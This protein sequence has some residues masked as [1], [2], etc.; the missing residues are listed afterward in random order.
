MRER[1]F[2]PLDMKDTSFHVPADKIDRLPTCYRFNHQM[3]QLEVYDGI[4]DSAWREPAMELGSGGLVGSADDYFAF[5]RMMLDKGRHG[6]EQVLSRASV[7][8]MTSDQLTSNSVKGPNSSS[9]RTAAGDL[10]WVWTRNATTSTAAPDASVG[11]AGSAF[12]RTRTPRRASSASCSPNAWPIRRGHRRYI[13]TSGRSPTERCCKAAGPASH[14]TQFVGADAGRTTTMVVPSPD[15]P[16]SPLLP[17]APVLPSL[18][19]MPVAPCGPA[20]PGTVTTGPGTATM[21]PGT[22]TTGPGT[23]TTAAGVFTTV[24][25]SQATRLNGTSRAAIHMERFI[26]N[27]FV[28]TGAL[29]WL[30][31]GREQPAANQSSPRFPR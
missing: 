26:G 19:C 8:L 29:E 14:V 15:L 28:S 7:G 25:L 9:A 23:A 13:A 31:V 11:T 30:R 6:R 4:A 20:G 17:V 21:G 16:V 2:E 1:V 12:L 5:M 22:A 3:Q 24:G 10:A 27:P 18:P